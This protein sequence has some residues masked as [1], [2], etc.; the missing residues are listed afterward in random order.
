MIHIAFFLSHIPPPPPLY[1]LC[2]AG[3]YPT[4]VANQKELDVYTI[5]IVKYGLYIL[6]GIFGVVACTTARR[7]LRAH[8]SAIIQIVILYLCMLTSLTTIALTIY[9][10]VQTRDYNEWW[11][12]LISVFI[13]LQRLFFIAALSSAARSLRDAEKDAAVAEVVCGSALQLNASSDDDEEK[14]RQ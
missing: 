4:T 6:A 8:K 2:T 10:A 13:I 1:L 7:A 12:Y 14:G 11:S 9:S 5:N 3:D